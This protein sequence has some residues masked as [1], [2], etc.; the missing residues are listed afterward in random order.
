MTRSDASAS[1]LIEGCDVVLPDGVIRHGVI[2]ACDGSILFAGSRDRVPGDLPAGCR[3]IPAEGML[4]CPALWDPHIHGCGGVSTENMTAESLAE[5]AGFLA[6]HGVGAFLPTIVAD[7]GHVARL[8]EAIIAAGDRPD[9]RG[10]IPGIYVEGPFVSVARRGAIP[11]GLVQPVSIATLDRFV[12]LSRGK[13]R[14]MTFAPELPGASSLVTR[15]REKG[16]LPCL[17]H[18]DASYDGLRGWEDFA[19]L[20][21]THLFNGMS[22]VSHRDPGLAQWALVNRDVHT[23]LNCDGTHVHDAGIHLALRARPWGK[24]VLISDAVAPAGLPPDE[25]GSAGLALYGKPLFARGNGLYYA[26]SGVLVGSRAL[27]TDGLRR[28]VTEFHVPVANA[29]SMATLNTARLLGFSRKGA[30]LAGYDADV[31]LFSHDFSRCSFTSWEGRVLFESAAS[32][33]A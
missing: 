22:G 33:E 27:L 4:A 9:L 13:L 3:T 21:V 30:L 20:N 24:M 5:M 2:L 6:A 17:G 1:F 23:E 25:P 8:G 12:E 15:M 14:L 19:P 16:I 29:I 31:A 11:E 10:R 32:Q 26:D 7:E 18:S 28:L